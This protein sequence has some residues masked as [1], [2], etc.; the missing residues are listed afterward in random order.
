MYVPFTSIYVDECV[1]M[2]YFERFDRQVFDYIV[3]LFGFIMI[4]GCDRWW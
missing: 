3:F 1:C 4:D 2:H